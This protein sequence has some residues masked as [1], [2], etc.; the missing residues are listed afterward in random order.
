MEL[1]R[2]W[3]RICRAMQLEQLM[4]Q[5]GIR[6]VEENPSA[7]DY[8][9]LREQL[10]WPA[11]SEAV[12]S[13][14]LQGSLYSVC[15]YKENSIIGMGRVVGD[16]AIYF[17]VQDVIVLPEFQH[18]GYGRLIMGCIL[19]YLEPFIK[20]HAYISL[21]ARKNTELFYKSL[22]FEERPTAEKGPG[23]YYTLDG[24]L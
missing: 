1:F 3:L 6:V 5:I 20:N 12:Y 16:G 10:T 2:T 7:K 8:S 11:F 18:N 13:K 22:G 4:M 15:L 9:E 21:M 19:K 24:T 17:Y 14:A 23:M